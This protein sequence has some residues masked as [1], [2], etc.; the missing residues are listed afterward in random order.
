MKE[1]AMKESYTFLMAVLLMDE[2][3]VAAS[4][5]QFS[6]QRKSPQKKAKKRPLLQK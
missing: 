3:E 4:L 2:D 1:G 5:Q 6:G